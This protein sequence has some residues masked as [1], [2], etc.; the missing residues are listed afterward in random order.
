MGSSYPLFVW[1]ALFPF[2][3]QQG[4]L[5]HPRRPGKRNRTNRRSYVTRQI[6]KEKESEQAEQK[7]ESWITHLDIS[8]FRFSSLPSGVSHSMS[9]VHVHVVPGFARSASLWRLAA[10]A[11]RAGQKRELRQQRTTEER[12]PTPTDKKNHQVSTPGGLLFKVRH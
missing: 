9:N 3:G 1:F 10:I 4:R 12:K 11:E 7:L 8:F 2:P 5:R 6:G